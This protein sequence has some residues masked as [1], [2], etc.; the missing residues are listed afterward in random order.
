MGGPTCSVI[1][2]K[3]PA[4][5]VNVV[6]ISK[7]RVDSW[8]S[9]QLPIYEPGLEEIVKQCR[10]KNLFFSTDVTTHI[11]EADLIFISVNTPT[12]S[13]GVGECRSS[14]V[15]CCVLHRTTHLVCVRLYTTPPLCAVGKGRAPDLKFIES[16]ARQIAEATSEPKI[17]VEK[18]TVPVRAAESISKILHCNAPDVPFQVC[19]CEWVM[20]ARTHTL[21]QSHTAWCV[22]LCRVVSGCV[23]SCRVVSGRVWMCLVVSG[24]VWLYSQEVYSPHYPMHK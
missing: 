4:V 16:A 12:K 11:R 2:W 6:D 20:H 13:F 14:S 1:A 15:L 19:M 21:D 5:T 3:V 22:W 8:N 18:S 7:E 9:D 10:G 17:V 24:Y 23:W